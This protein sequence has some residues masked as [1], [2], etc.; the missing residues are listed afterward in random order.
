MVSAVFHSPL[1]AAKDAQAAA[2]ADKP[3]VATVEPPK[4]VVT[5]R[6]PFDW[7][8][9][10]LKVVPPIVGIAVL[11]GVWALLTIKSSAFPTPAATF[12]EAVVMFSDPFYSNGPNDQGI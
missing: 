12:K 5:S 3:R 10:F 11:I 6:A 4:V 1:D 2:A 8:G 9:L 7:S